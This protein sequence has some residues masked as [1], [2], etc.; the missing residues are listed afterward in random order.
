MQTFAFNT[1]EN[2]PVVKE[3]QVKSYVK[4]EKNRSQFCYRLKMSWFKTLFSSQGSSS[5]Q[6][7]SQEA[8]VKFTKESIQK[9]DTDNKKKNLIQLSA[10]LKKLMKPNPGKA[11][12]VIAGV[13]RVHYLI[14]QE[15]SMDGGKMRKPRSRGGN[16]LN[17]NLRP[18]NQV[19]NQK[20]F[21]CLKL[22]ARNHRSKKTLTKVKQLKR[23]T[24]KM[25]K[26]L[27]FI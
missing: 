12:P 4:N 10:N 5:S 16:H 27:V 1:V 8:T 23:M 7:S 24:R 21:S 18:K 2:V 6:C 11:A 26:V 14:H 13:R 20:R 19:K 3:V 25:M 17:P 9:D 22:P 15:K